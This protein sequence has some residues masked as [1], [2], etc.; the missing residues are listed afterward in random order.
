MK[1]YYLKKTLGI[2]K[3]EYPNLTDIEL[4]EYRYGLESFYLT[5]TKSLIII[6]IAFILGI[7]KELLILFIFFN[8]LRKYACGLHATKSWI[9]LCSS[10]MIFL[11]LPFLAKN[12]VIPIQIKII[13]GIIAIILFLVYAP[14]DTKKAPIIYKEK[15]EKQKIISTILCI[16]FIISSILISNSTISNLILFSVCVESIMILP[17]TYRLFHLPYN[18]YKNYVMR[19]NL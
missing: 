12:I 17:L 13:L 3:K 10:S 7:G 18:N 9:C 8:L 16:V 19:Y 2:L 15:R 4:D 11:T 5:V 6:P 1:Q 14:A